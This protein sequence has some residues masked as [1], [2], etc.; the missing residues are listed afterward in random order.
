[1]AD[2]IELF[3][4]VCALFLYKTIKISVTKTF[5]IINVQPVKKKRYIR[6][7]RSVM[8]SITYIIIYFIVSLRERERERGDG[9]IGKQQKIAIIPGACSFQLPQDV[10][11]VSPSQSGNV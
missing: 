11:E 4:L 7:F 3:T 5:I 2:C 8:I 10:Q 9:I 1:M 6:I